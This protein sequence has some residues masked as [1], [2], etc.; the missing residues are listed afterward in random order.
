VDRSLTGV[1]RIGGSHLLLYRVHFI[2]KPKRP[3]IYPHRGI[4]PIPIW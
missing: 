2:D 1:P 4:L 3:Y